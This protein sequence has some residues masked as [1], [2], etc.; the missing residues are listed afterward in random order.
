MGSIESVGSRYRVNTSA[1]MGL[2]S[3]RKTTRCTPA[4]ASNVNPP[5]S[6]SMES[7]PLSVVTASVSSLT[8]EKWFTKRSTARN[9]SPTPPFHIS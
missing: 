5:P 8:P 9:E 7:V 1:S 3:N 4:S 2:K 6:T